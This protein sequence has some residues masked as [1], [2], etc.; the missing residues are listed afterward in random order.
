MFNDPGKTIKTAAIVLFFIF[1][2]AAFC[3]GIKLM[4]ENDGSTLLGILTIAGGTLFAW[5][6]SLMIYGFGH[7]IK[8]VEK[9]A[10]EKEAE[11]PKPAP[12][13]RPIDIKCPCCGKSL[14]NFDEKTYPGT[15]RCSNCQNLF[16][17]NGK[18]AA[19]E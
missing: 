3:V 6:S 9:I 16:T 19:K 11:A 8:K 4:D 14:P 15:Y 1:T 13:I 18:T 5:V 7:L 17:F 2:I 12:I 10:D